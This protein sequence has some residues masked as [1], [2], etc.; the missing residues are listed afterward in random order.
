MAVLNPPV[1][2]RR[3]TRR[4]VSAGAALQAAPST[5]TVTAPKTPG[6]KKRVRFS[7]PGLEVP[8]SDE[9]DTGPTGS[10]GLTPM[11]ER[12]SLGESASK[13]R[14]SSRLASIGDTED[15]EPA[16]PKAKGKA[17]ARK[18]SSAKR[19]PTKAQIE[20]EVARLRA[21]LV[22]RDAE[23]ERLRDETVMQ[24]TGRIV[25]LDN[26]IRS[27]RAELQK[28]QYPAAQTEGEDEVVGNATDVDNDGELPSRTFYDWTLGPR[29][30]YLD[31]YLYGGD[32]SGD[33][34]MPDAAAFSTPSRRRKSPDD[35]GQPRSLSGSFPTPPCTSPTQPATP[36]SV[37]KP[38]RAETP[39]RAVGVQASL[40]DAEK[41]S[42][43]EELAS[44]RLELSKL[45][46]T[47]E[48]QAS[49]QAHLSE[50][51]SIAAPPAAGED[52]GEGQQLD[53]EE[54]LH[55]MLRQLQERTLDLIDVTSSLRSLGFPG[56]DASEIISSITSGLRI[57]RLEME[58]VNPGNTSLPLSHHGSE[59]L[60]MI[61]EKIRVLRRQA[62]EGAAEVQEVSAK[63]DSLQQQLNDR[64]NAIDNTRAQWRVDQDAVA[65]RDI[66]I[67]ELER[68]LD[69]VRGEAAGYV[70]DIKAL[71]SWTERL[72]SEG[73]LAQARL[74]IDLDLAR[75]KLEQRD[76]ATTD[77]EAKLAGAL[78]MVEALEA[79]IR[80]LQ[81]RKG[82]DSRAQNK[83][84]GDV[85]ALK[86]RRI[87]E[88]RREI[89]ALSTRLRDAQESLV[90]VQRECQVASTRWHKAEN[91]ANV[92]RETIE[93]MKDELR[94][95]IAIA[96]AER[97]RRHDSGVGLAEGDEDEAGAEAEAEAEDE[98]VAS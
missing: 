56:S 59:L 27:L 58:Y 82:A 24:D 88:L 35:E 93:Q 85:L 60:I 1:A 78:E 5:V 67:T 30:A 34:A 40:P 83:A 76:A 72:D 52:G 13:R 6:S 64:C 48:T 97:K 90:S 66:R 89:S 55:M 33:V 96:A 20:A 50:M 84:H 98:P 53:I 37:H 23:I 28:Q 63:R 46:N 80:D 70:Q 7:D 2:L 4:C 49:V 25:E 92:A 8:R 18:G 44:L 14:R 77:L 26:Q 36:F 54:H 15:A 16:T 32:D 81:L 45:Q 41:E 71:E 73:R 62:K 19:A 47:F 21:E 69:R 42:L 94:R 65:E 9:A 91:E 31:R 74:Q 29:D 68:S 17:R 11:V 87:L 12:S 61:I 43:K 51:L 22:N 10:T 3:S 95:T 39:S 57:A 86:D 75:E 79:Q 38:A